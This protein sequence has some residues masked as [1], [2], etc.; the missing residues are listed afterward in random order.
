MQKIRIIGAL[1][2]L[3]ALFS[4]GYAEKRAIL[5]QVSQ[6]RDPKIN[7]FVGTGKAIVL[8]NQRMKNALRRH[9]FTQFVELSEQQATRAA[10][11]E[12]MEAVR[13][14]TQPSDV[15]VFYFS[16]HGAVG[17]QG[18]S[19]AP[20]DAIANDSSGDISGNEIA[21]WARS[22]PT[23]HVVIVLDCCF[24]F[25]PLGRRPVVIYPKVIAVRREQANSWGE[26][27][28]LEKGVVLT[29][30]NLGQSAYQMTTG[31]YDRN[32][33]ASEWVGIF[34][35]ALCTIIEQAANQ[36]DLKYQELVQQ[37]AHAIGW[38]FQKL[39]NPTRQTPQILGSSRLRETPIFQTVSASESSAAPPSPT[40]D[41][42]VSTPPVIPAQDSS[43]RIYI[44]RSIP[45]EMAEKI[46]TQLEARLRKLP[47][48]DRP[49]CVFTESRYNATHVVEKYENQIILSDS[50]GITAVVLADSTSDADKTATTVAEKMNSVATNHAALQVIIDAY[51]Q[52][53]AQRQA[54][55]QLG[56]DRE[57]YRVDDRVTVHLT[58]S[59]D[60]YL[61]LLSRTQDDNLS[62]L[63]PKDPGENQLL[64]AS[65]RYK[66]PQPGVEYVV[67]PPAG[68]DFIC[69]IIVESE[70]EQK[71]IL[72]LLGVRQE[73]SQSESEE[74]VGK[75]VV[76]VPSPKNL[77]EA[78]AKLI[79]EDKCEIS[80][81]D[82][83][84]F[85]R[86]E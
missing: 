79:R 62:F 55:L 15:V 50:Y 75:G 7:S 81:V 77:E 36:H 83:L 33:G 12:Q 51:H 20:H 5:I 44:D 14:Q 16:G 71:R 43:V 56:V 42:Q 47:E 11:R 39:N 28:K 23:E 58:P 86:E 2:A 61:I 74:A 46:R 57:S 21:Q 31:K 45:E 35:H 85:P 26:L 37:T 19:L 22:L 54:R 8:D 63:Y 64:K 6:Y 60:G 69:A 84:V 49:K 53:F 1:T 17:R 73:A 82:F 27:A 48:A 67:T 10:I 34:T 59:R 76:R 24:Y 41:R 25:Q 30:A 9:G 70:A 13:K 38:G 78:L 40:S 29:A 52:H 65:S 80:Y 68:K 72:E 32:T 66:F 3:V 18:V 4:V